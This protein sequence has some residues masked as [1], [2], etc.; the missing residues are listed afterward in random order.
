[1][2][3][4]ILGGTGAMGVPL[5]KR[6]AEIDNCVYVTSRKYHK[7]DEG[8]QYICGNAK[9]NSFLKKILE[10]RFDVIIDF[11]VYSTIEFKS[12]IDLLL[13]STG[14]YIFISSSRC[15][16]NSTQLITERTNRL[17]DSVEDNNYLL[18][19]DYALAK[20]RQENILYDSPKK[21]WTIIRPYITY[22]SQR[23]QLGCYEKEYWLYRVLNNKTIVLPED[24]LNSVTTLTFG[25]DV[26]NCIFRLVGNKN[27][28]EECYTITTRESHTWREIL[29]YYME[30][31]SK[32]MGQDIKILFIPTS[33]EMYEICDEYQIKYDRLYNRMFDIS[34][35]DA[36]IGKYDFVS[37]KTGLE[38]CIDDFFSNSQ[39]RFNRGPSAKFEAWSDRQSHEVSS[40]SEFEGM[41]EKLR[42]IKWRF[43][44][45]P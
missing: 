22:N 18:T 35:L 15:Y 38:K 31:I 41:R 21:N 11:M 28:L 20:G 26:A 24:I 27:A 9:D 37:T 45:E 14:Q 33:K 43:L 34:K 16:A 3:I 19:D 39:E 1:M 30:I 44:N 6:L 42:Y 10:E 7:N 29:D 8:I 40:L 36:A 12:R 2:K 32:K 5:V 4:L 23:L 13:N 25:D 17:L